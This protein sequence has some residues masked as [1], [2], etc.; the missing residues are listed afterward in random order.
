M[1]PAMNHASA[2]GSLHTGAL[3]LAHL[4]FRIHPAHGIGPDG[5]CTCGKACD[6]PGKHARLRD[7]PAQ[8]T[9]DVARINEWWRWWPTSNVAIA[10][11]RG[12]MVLD[13]DGP[14]GEASLADLERSH[15]PLAET[16]LVRTSRGWHYY[17]STPT[18]LP[19]SASKIGPHIDV[20][21]D[22]GMAIAPPSKHASG[23]VYEWSRDLG[24]GVAPAPGWLVGL[25]VAAKPTM[26]AGSGPF[27]ATPP[28]E[29]VCL[30]RDGA[31]EG[32][33][34]DAA[35]R[36]AGLALRKLPA[37]V[38]VEVVRLWN[39]AR[40]SPPLPRDELDRLLEDVAAMEARRRPG[41]AA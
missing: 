12:L 33:R 17:F 30:I 9:V 11:G 7:W 8:A 20:R 18:P 38:A 31:P 28:G 40:C 10:T 22:G 34:H 35:L 27:L 19:N 23:A 36:L 39:E 13:V 25:A 2:T 4:G 21:A 5:H 41:E 3:A 6:A 32:Q 24:W 15:G 37:H 16:A 26:I 29:W 1:N 14:E